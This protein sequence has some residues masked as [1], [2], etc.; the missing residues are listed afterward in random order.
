M[1][2]LFTVR[3]NKGSYSNALS[4]VL[5][6]AQATDLS[7]DVEEKDRAGRSPLPSYLAKA[8]VFITSRKDQSQVLN[9]EEDSTDALE[10]SLALQ[11]V[12]VNAKNHYTNV[13]EGVEDSPRRSSNVQEES[14]EMP[15]SN[16][17]MRDEPGLSSDDNVQNP[18]LDQPNVFNNGQEIL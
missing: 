6:V 9:A 11:E 7:V 10:E 13:Q 2:G 1:L 5:R 4:T 8:T 17:V 14:L 3:I 16:T 15:N 12:L 18:L